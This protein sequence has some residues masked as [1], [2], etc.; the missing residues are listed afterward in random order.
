M[1]S[2]VDFDGILIIVEFGIVCI[3]HAPLSHLY[4]NMYCMM[5]IKIAVFTRLPSALD[6]EIK[7]PKTP[8]CISVDYLGVLSGTKELMAV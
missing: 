6:L 3:M 8:F 5:F 4:I 2:N 1:N 7:G